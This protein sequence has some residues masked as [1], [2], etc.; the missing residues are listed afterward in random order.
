VGLILLKHSNKNL[1][2]TPG[3]ACILAHPLW[4]YQ[5]QQGR[6]L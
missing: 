1:E 5:L 2:L 3:L 4:V 6:T